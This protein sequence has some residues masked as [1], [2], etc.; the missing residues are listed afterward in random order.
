[1]QIYFVIALI[2]AVL[3]AIFAIQNSAPVHV[4]FL[5]WEI[6]RIS[7][8]LVILG[9]AAIGALIVL[10][11]GA[12]KQIKLI[13]QVRQLTQQYN[14][15]KNEHQKLK[16]QL[17]TT[18]DQTVDVIQNENNESGS[19]NFNEENEPDKDTNKI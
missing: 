1:M 12:G 5:F 15:L 13:W 7:Q 8:V 14:Q 16:Q 3:V 6:Q 10:F 19:N 2:F 9:A 17:N 18:T 4:Q 11:M